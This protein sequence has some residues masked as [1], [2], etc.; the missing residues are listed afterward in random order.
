M[1]IGVHYVRALRLLMGE[2]DRVFAS[3][4]MQVNTKLT[5]EDSIQLLLATHG[6]QGHVL[7]NWS[8]PRGHLPDLII[9]GDG[10]TIQLWPGAAYLDHYPARPL[11]LT[12]LLSYVRPSWLA[13]RLIEP[14]L[15][16]IRRRVPGNDGSGYLAEVKEFLAAVSEQRPP[17]SSPVDAR[18]DLEIVLRGYEALRNEAWVTIARVTRARPL[19]GYDEDRGGPAGSA[20]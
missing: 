1:D 4:A 12:R 17:A 11:P 8:S 3:R 6:W 14:A 15:Q 7:L 16:R 2:P 9:M 18:R 10:G 5:G 20:L 13:E 19:I